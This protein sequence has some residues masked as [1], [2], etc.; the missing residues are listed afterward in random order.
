MFEDVMYIENGDPNIV[1]IIL[2]STADYVVKRRRH[3]VRQGKQLPVVENVLVACHDPVVAKLFIDIFLFY[4][5]SQYF[6]GNNTG[7]ISN[8]ATILIQNKDPTK[9][10]KVIFDTVP[11]SIFA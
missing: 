9:I 6:R 7:G 10:A 4:S 3:R 1:R 11:K 5:P 8:M 2:E